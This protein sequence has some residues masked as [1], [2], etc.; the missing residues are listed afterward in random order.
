MGKNGKERK[1]KDDNAFARPFSPV[2]AAFKK[3]DK[4]VPAPED[5]PGA[6]RRENAPAAAPEAGT[7][8]EQ[9]LQ[10]ENAWPARSASGRPSHQP[11]PE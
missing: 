11:E 2:A 7:H 6:A 1:A 8:P 9:M 10:T 3:R 4:A 5:V